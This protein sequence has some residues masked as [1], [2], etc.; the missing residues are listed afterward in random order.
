MNPSAGALLVVDDSEVNRTSLAR[1]LTTQGYDVTV[2]TGGAQ[3]LALLAER[4]FDVVLLD[5]MMNDVN[6]LDVLRTVR[7]IHSPSELPVIMVT[8]KDQSEDIVRGL[9]LGANDYVIKPLDLPVLLARVQTQLSLKR[10]VERVL[11]LEKN[12][13]QRNQELTAAN[14]K[15]TVANELMKQD[16]E[17][18]V[19][20]QE[21][22]LPQTSPGFPAANFAWLF[23]PCAALAGD[24]LNVFAL[25]EQHVGMYV[26]DVSGHGVAAALLAVTLSHILSPRRTPDSILIRPADGQPSD[27]IVPPAEVA[28]NLSRRFPLDPVTEQ[29]FTIIYGIL[30]LETG[31][32]RYACAGHPGPIHIPADGPAVQPECTGLPVG[33]GKGEYREYRIELDPGDRLYFYSDGLF[34]AMNPERD[35]F[36]KAR[37]CATLDRRRSASLADS[38][39]AL[40]EEVSHWAGDAPPQDDISILAV[41]YAGTPARKSKGSSRR[42]AAQAT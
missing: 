29:Y 41:E 16:L 7:E 18:A 40:W 37:L 30:D 15:L 17:A 5:V 34:E 20:I 3:A 12:L 19:R 25:D 28:A 42:A 8:A 23:K 31:V 14:A 10:A 21:A 38:V 35:S 27:E 1:L 39:R 26:L 4:R 11:R 32:I 9:R 22:F 6:G 24:T 2:G 36:G 13:E 33:V